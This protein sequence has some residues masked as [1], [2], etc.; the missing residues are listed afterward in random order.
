MHNSMYG[1]VAIETKGVDARNTDALECLLALCRVI[2][3]RYEITQND[4]EFPNYPYFVRLTWSGWPVDFFEPRKREGGYTTYCKHPVDGLSSA[5]RSAVNDL[6][7]NGESFRSGFI[8]FYQQITGRDWLAGRE[9]ADK[10][11]PSRVTP[12]KVRMVREQAQ[13][14]LMQAREA[15]ERAGGNVERAIYNLR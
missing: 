13:C 15:L 12:D 8:D 10:P 2:G 9:N 1:T 4:K 5:I 3:L 6:C 14:G 7:R 11:L